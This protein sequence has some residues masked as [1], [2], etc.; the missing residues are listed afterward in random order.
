MKFIK[1]KFR[2]MKIK[3]D[4]ERCIGCGKCKEICPSVFQLNEE[5]KATVITETIDECEA[6]P[7]GE[8][9]ALVS[10]AV[11]RAADECMMEAI[12]IDMEIK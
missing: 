8:Q 11:K 1:D 5:G 10:E 7:Q 9:C 12:D 4:Q 3:V 2:N 6:N